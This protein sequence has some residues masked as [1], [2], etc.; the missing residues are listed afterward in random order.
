[1]GGIR[2]II[3]L[4]NQPTGRKRDIKIANLIK[5]LLG[6]KMKDFYTDIY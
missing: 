1:M 6:I 4:E 2:N 3:S 5:N